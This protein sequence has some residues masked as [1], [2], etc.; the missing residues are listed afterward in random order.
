MYTQQ[1]F[2]ISSCNH[3][4]MTRTKTNSSVVLER[5]QEINMHQEINNMCQEEINMHEIHNMR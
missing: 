5:N 3:S 2:S 4:V 1:A